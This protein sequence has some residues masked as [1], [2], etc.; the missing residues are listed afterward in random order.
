MRTYLDHNATS[1]LRPSAKT[2]ML[3]ALG[4]GNASSIHAEGR[5]ARALLDGA[6]EEIASVLGVLP[7]MIVFTASGTEANN[8]AIKGTPVERLILSR[9]EH[10]S[11]IEAAKARNMPIEWVPVDALGRIRLDALENILKRST[12]PS[13]L[14]VM[15][16]NNETG[17][18]QPVRQIAEL[19]RSFNVL[20][21]T[22]A[23]QALGR[24][25][26]NFAV[27][28]ADLMTISA[29]KIGGPMG[30]AALIVR[31]GLDLTVQLQGG[32]QELRRRA[33]TENVAAVAGFAA[34]LAESLSDTHILRDRLESELEQVSPDIQIFGRNAE[35]IGNTS[36]FA[37]PAFSADATLISLDLDGV[38]VS[39]G[40][41][42]SSGKVGRS[43]VLDA[44]GVS[45]EVAKSAIRVSFGWNSAPADVDAFMAAWRRMIDRTFP[46]L[47]MAGLDPVISSRLQQMP[48]SSP[49]MTVK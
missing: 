28:G 15:L 21:H 31:N 14:S 6:R 34:A 38:A 43:H 48:G 46:S 17:V 20:F 26:V 45:S 42:C 25:P 36:C 4:A 9:I 13:L 18:I 24:M 2:A 37:V 39:S 19:A 22:D 44:M 1:P 8:W 10:P 23:V 11:I 30:A 29:H 27:L 3:S 40:S 12:L 5:T 32:G 16:V 7:Q 47:V 41:A 35:R 33:G 49:G